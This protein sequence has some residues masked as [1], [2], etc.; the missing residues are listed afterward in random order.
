M[1]TSL[2]MKVLF[3]LYVSDVLKNFNHITIL[4]N[5]SVPASPPPPSWY[6]CS[7]TKQYATCPQFYFVLG[8]CAEEPRAFLF[9]TLY[10]SNE[11]GYDDYMCKCTKS[12]TLQRYIIPK[13]QKNLKHAFLILFIRGLLNASPEKKVAVFQ[14][15]QLLVRISWHSYDQRVI[16]ASSW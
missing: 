16:A 10:Q 14:N 12:L 5:M 13:L 8:K 6:H 9:S 11:N 7:T 1:V 4:K 3:W 15:Q 2:I